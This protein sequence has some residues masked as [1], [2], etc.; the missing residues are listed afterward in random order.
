MTK[1]QAVQDSVFILILAWVCHYL[2]SAYG[3]NPTDE[4]FV[5]S[6][7]SRLLNGQIPH[8]DFSSVR[9]LGYAYLHIPELLFSPSQF[10]L[11]SRFVFWMETA[12]IACLWIQF[13]ESRL[14]LS[15]TALQRYALMLI[16][17]IFNVHYFPNAV[18]H[19]IDGLLMALIGFRILS[20]QHRYSFTGFIFIGFAALCKQNYILLLPAALLLTGKQ[21]LLRN[22]FAGLLPIGI[23]VAYVVLHNGWND[24][25]TQLS[26]H[27]ELIKVGILHY[28]FNYFFISGLLL[29]LLVRKFDFPKP[30]FLTAMLLGLSALMLTN[31]Y[32][33]SAGFFVF[34]ALAAELFK[35]HQSRA[36]KVATL[37]TLLLAWSVSISV[38][39]N[40]PALF[41]GSI[42]TFLILKYYDGKLPNIKW[43][44]ASL[45]L[46][47][48]IVFYISRTTNIYRDAAAKE[49]AYPLDGIVQGASGIYTN[50]HT[51][52]VLKELD[53]LKTALPEL[54]VVPDFTA[55]A[56]P[57]APY[58]KIRTE[59]PNK[60][61][62]PNDRI[63]A[64]V[65]EGIENDSSAVFLI[66]LYQTALLKDGFTPLENNG[67]DY[68]IV[69]F[70]RTNFP[71]VRYTS[72]F[73][74]R[75]R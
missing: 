9:P 27:R 18:L 70:I 67:M 25:I 58:S 68:P 57:D 40:T 37:L 26:G 43:I 12:L 45:T 3:F 36:E 11:T 8:V 13:V 56:I 33:G 74:I 51:Y 69:R 38:G 41:N 34:G 39:Y 21:S 2:F 35:R 44:T 61:E 75:T 10:F 23:Y 59:W 19:T 63:L 49:L 6:S 20:A 54:T 7:S 73:E 16:T 28:L 47:I 30:F 55:C 60:T 48:C 66:P 42:L 32:H 52:A 53:S 1:K 62:I 22:L 14:K 4:G 5:L 15:F 17:F 64:K 72:Y 46:V 50:K 31:R 65:T 29:A 71:K 24:L